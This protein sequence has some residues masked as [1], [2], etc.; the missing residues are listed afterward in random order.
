M[1]EAQGLVLAPVARMAAKANDPEPPKPFAIF[2]D[3]ES[4]GLVRFYMSREDIMQFAL[5]ALRLICDS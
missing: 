2:L 3:S 5:G 4:D 1:I